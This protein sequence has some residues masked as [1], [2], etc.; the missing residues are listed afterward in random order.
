LKLRG[1][2]IL[3]TYTLVSREAHFADT[4][5]DVGG[6]PVG[7]PHFTVIGG[8]CAIESPEQMAQTAE[9]VKAAGAQLLRAGAFKPRT[10]PYSFQGL[11][12]EGLRLLH[13]V[14]KRVRLPSVTEVM[15]IA[16]IEDVAAH[17]D[18]LQVGTRNMQNFRL[19]KALGRSTK[20]VLLKR[21]MAARVE[22]LLFAAEYIVNAGNP[23]VILC[24]RGIRTFETSTRNTLDL[25]AV[26]LL[27]Q[28]THL[29]VIVD[30]SHGTG[31]RSLV[32]PMAK[33]AMMC[34]ADG[35]MIETHRNPEEALSDADQAMYPDQFQKLMD[36]LRLLAPHAGKTWAPCASRPTSGGLQLA[37]DL[38]L[39]PI[40]VERQARNVG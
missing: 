26:P 29:P 1:E 8:P 28:Q 32:G 30:P 31:I 14:S 20:P 27:K 25:N 22:E 21:G 7:G 18:M 12:L 13:S 11:E 3:A 10:N 23:N 16:D 38:A 19:L 17:A 15:E 34:G 33:A 39:R 35:L 4:I 2:N 37:D 5:V 40:S 9:L 24:E 6:V 36:E